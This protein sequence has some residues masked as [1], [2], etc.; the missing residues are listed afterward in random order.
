MAMQNQ[1]AIP[2]ALLK[3]AGDR[4][5]IKT[6]EF[7]KAT[8]RATQTIR[9]HHALTGHCFGIRPRKVGTFLLWPV[10]EIAALL[11]GGAK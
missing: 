7:A 6:V 3:I 11:N 1:A 9:K 8:S 10:C 5:H 2:P 4:D